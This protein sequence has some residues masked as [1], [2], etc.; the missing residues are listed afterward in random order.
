MALG[1]AAMVEAQQLPQLNDQYPAL[2]GHKTP[3]T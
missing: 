3:L 1:L 2:T